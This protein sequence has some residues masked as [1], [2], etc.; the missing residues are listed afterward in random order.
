MLE[1][2]IYKQELPFCEPAQPDP[3]KMLKFRV[4]PLDPNFQPRGSSKQVGDVFESIWGVCCIDFA[5]G[6]G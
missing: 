4:V 5:Y 3:V 6:N 1:T 2:T